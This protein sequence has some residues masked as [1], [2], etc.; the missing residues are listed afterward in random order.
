MEKQV[1]T[2]AI[3]PVAVAAILILAVLAAISST[4]NAAERQPWKEKPCALTL[5]VSPS[6]QGA[7]SYLLKGRLNCAGGSGLGGQTI[8][9]KNIVWV[10]FGGDFTTMISYAMPT[11]LT[12]Q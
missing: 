11:H 9:T 3:A 7:K 6:T 12:A 8:I 2:S 5:N 10:Y 1:A 4:G